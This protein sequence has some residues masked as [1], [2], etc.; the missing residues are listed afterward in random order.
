MKCMFDNCLPPKLAKTMNYLEGDDGIEVIHLKEKFSADT[1]DVEWISALAKEGGWFV[2][3]R[4]NQIKKQPHEIKAWQE[5]NLPIVF[6]QKSWLSFD[7]W[8]IAWRLVKYWP[9]IK[10]RIEKA[11]V[12]ESIVLPV[13]GN[14]EVIRSTQLKRA[15]NL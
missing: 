12:N 10:G 1:Q 4:D 2:I 7:F 6:M 15:S 9:D 14:L 11:K 3:T 8:N 13:H 5:S